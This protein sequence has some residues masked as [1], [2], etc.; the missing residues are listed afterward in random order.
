[1]AAPSN[2]TPTTQHKRGAAPREGD[3]KGRIAPAL[4]EAIKLRVHDDLTIDAACAKA[5][6]SVSGYHKA[7]LRPHVQAF[8]ADEQRLY[9]QRVDTQKAKFKARAYEVAASF[10][11]E[12]ASPADKRWA[13]EFFTRD[14]APRRGDAPQVSVNIA[15]GYEF[16]R[17]G[18][19]VVDMIDGTA[20][21]TVSGALVGDG[22][23][24]STG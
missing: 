9:I 7:L 13:V 8:L 15:Q 21:D 14:D 18:Q 11:A 24:T 19:R 16:V 6:I 23:G 22:D 2:N 17:P 5:G 1:M 10:L 12:N 3:A 20:P 4:R